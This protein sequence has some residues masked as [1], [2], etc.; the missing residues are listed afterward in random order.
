MRYSKYISIGNGR[1]PSYYIRKH[2]NQ[3]EAY[4]FDWITT[5][6]AG[7]CKLIEFGPETLFWDKAQF[8]ITDNEPDKKNATVIHKS[9]GVVL[10]SEFPPGP[11]ALNF[12]QN[13]EMKFR[14]LAQKWH[15][16]GQMRNK[17]LFVRHLATEVE[18]LQIQNII[19]EVFP[20]LT[21]DILVVN[22]DGAN[23]EPWD[24]P[25]IINMCVNPTTDWKGDSQGWAHV[26]KT[27]C[28]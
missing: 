19:S 11:K 10:D 24:Q 20:N 9:L 13:V 26:F 16:I 5:P 25:G 1:Q 4:F 23:D 7:L 22:E 21:F 6:V 8:H 28:V 17:I 27:V 14:H 3:E 18:A 15:G 2:A 12:Y